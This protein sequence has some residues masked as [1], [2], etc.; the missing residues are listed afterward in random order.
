MLNINGFRRSDGS[1]RCPSS[2]SKKPK[3]LEIKKWNAVALWAWGRNH[4]M[5]LCIECQANQ[6][7]ATSEECTIAWGKFSAKKQ[8]KDDFSAGLREPVP[9]S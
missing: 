8:L 9:V 2:S 7:S 1:R 4:I 6:A 3:R 5:D